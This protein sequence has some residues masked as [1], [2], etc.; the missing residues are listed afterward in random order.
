MK[1]VFGNNVRLLLTRFDN[2][3]SHL[4]Y[5]NLDSNGPQNL[6]SNSAFAL[7][8]CQVEF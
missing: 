3:S 6:M 4:V 2:L 5:I 7:A 8:A 1:A